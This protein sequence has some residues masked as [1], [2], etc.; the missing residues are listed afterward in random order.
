MTKVTGFEVFKVTDE[1]LIRRGVKKPTKE[2]KP[3]IKPIPKELELLAVEAR[4]YK[5]AE[6]FVK[7]IPVDELRVVKESI[8]RELRIARFSEPFEIKLGGSMA[9]GVAKPTSD[10]DVF[11]I[12]TDK[13]MDFL[14]SPQA[15]DLNIKLD[16][17]KFNLA[18]KTTRPLEVLYFS[19]G[20]I[21]PIE[22][23]IEIG[24]KTKSQLI[25]FYAQATKGIKEVKPV[26]P[27]EEVKLREISKITTA[28]ARKMAGEGLDERVAGLGRP[29]RPP[30]PP[31]LE[32]LGLKEKPRLIT[33]TKPEDVLL[34]E[35]IRL[36]ARGAKI[37]VAGA[38][39]LTKQELIAKFKDSRN[40]IRQIQNDLMNYIKDNLP[41]STRGKF[42]QA[43]IGNLTKKREV[44]IFQRVEKVKEEIVRREVISELK[45]M[46]K[47]KNLAV[48]Y[49]KQI[50]ETLKD[51]DLVKPTENTLKKLRGLQEYIEKEGM[52][53][54][55]NPKQIEAL[56][57]LT[58]KNVGQM[59]LDELQELK[60]TISHLQQLGRL[61]L[62]LKYKYN[63]RE[64]KLAINRLIASSGNID[65]KVSG[66]NTKWDMW[67][68]QTKKYYMDTLHTPRVADMIDGFNSY[69]GENA[70][71][72]KRLALKEEVAK[73]KTKTVTAS[74]LEEIRELGIKELTED[75]QIRMMINVRNREGAYDQVKTLMEKYGYK[76]IP[77]LT[78]RENQV[79]EI[80]KNH[81]NQYTDEIAAIYEEIENQPFKK[82]KEYILP[83]KYEKEFNILPSATIEQTRYRTTQTFRGFVYARQRGVK[84]LPR[85]D[86]LAIFEEAIN[87]QQWYINIQPELENIK[88]IVKNK[89]YTAKAG[90]MATNFWKNELDIV[91]RRGWSATAL[92]NPLLRQTRL[93]LNSA[94]LGYKVSSILMQPFAVF[95]A[96]AY[97]QSRYGTMAT[98]EILKEFSKA[99][100]I[101][102]YAKK[103]IEISPSLQLRRAGELAVEETL[104]AT[105]R[106][107]GLWQSLVR[108]GL[109]L[110]QKADVITAAGV[111][112]GILNVLKKYEVEN[113][114]AEAEFLMNM[115][116]GS[117]EVTYR[118]H[119]LSK[120]EGARSWFTFQ[121]FFLNRWG[122]QAHDLI[123]SGLIAQKGFWKKFSAL[124][125]LGIFVA[126]AIAEQ[127][128]REGIYN[129]ITGKKFRPSSML[130][131]A[132]LAIPGQI[133]YFGN[134]IEAA[135]RGGDANPPVI[136][137]VE[138]VYRGIGRMILGKK[139][140]TKIKGALQTTEAGITI[141]LG[142]PGTAQ[143]FDLLE[144]IFLGA[145]E[146]PPVVGGLKFNF[147]GEQKIQG[148]SPLKFNFTR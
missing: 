125:G 46:P 86:I 97:A 98:L 33:I 145:E 79:I 117:A 50:T 73:L 52:P 29:P 100:V 132:L 27:K 143:F 23:L 55:I 70:K 66:K 37:G 28:E 101:P 110:L 90:E 58:K 51:V 111:E 56:R 67:K 103:F 123:R 31:M 133:P 8:G 60:D 6:E 120:G 106:V 146:K 14:R 22:N 113:P 64:R 129:L 95:D 38:R 30:R 91:A 108:G 84:K 92:S 7:T 13:G 99:W 43:I 72:I 45:E 105:G 15:V 10:L 135:F 78:E 83:I 5:S 147:G 119:I 144:R 25:D 44:S 80:L 136:R 140:E 127:K 53:L 93:N 104:K 85:K 115:V 54:G 148:I 3:E 75:Q 18:K 4:K 102:K 1:E 81:I 134:I 77:E 40:T 88:Y 118:P 76:E 36:E 63:E 87:E 11:V 19:K 82:L 35:R 12:T 116:S 126:G 42:L 2:V 24:V 112:K 74:A 121:T 16:Q 138:N 48:D 47:G 65:P 68:V 69:Q 21:K 114:E 96:I 71:Y 41:P 57:R 32:E 20:D 49:Q 122:I 17:L 124:I 61:K 139:P 107:K 26:L 141:G 128:A 62:N 142:I 89:E 131:D 137:I 130:K 109:S 34:R 59:T 39:Q 9:R 94:I